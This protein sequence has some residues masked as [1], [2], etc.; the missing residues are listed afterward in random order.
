M[1]AALWPGVLSCSRATTSPHASLCKHGGD[2]V[3]MSSVVVA[4]A[5]LVRS[6]A[7]A[8]ARPGWPRPPPSSCLSGNAHLFFSRSSHTRGL[9]FASPQACWKAAHSTPCSVRQARP[10]PGGPSPNLPGPTRLQ[11]RG[12]GPYLTGRWG[13]AE[14]C[15]HCPWLEPRTAARS[16]PR[17]GLAR[18]GGRS[19]ALCVRQSIVGTPFVFRPSW[20]RVFRA[21]WSRAVAPPAAA[22]GRR[23]RRL[24]RS[25]PLQ[26]LHSIS[27]THTDSLVFIRYRPSPSP[28][29]LVMPNPPFVW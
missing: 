14:H 27:H 15:T 10:L 17:P 25:C 6:P 9:V 2:L 23:Q 19:R 3:R 11:R 13:F 18:S 16:V 24:C 26:C 20:L 22:G 7:L 29:S 12:A 5:A 21:G 8:P 28:L 4:R 1:R